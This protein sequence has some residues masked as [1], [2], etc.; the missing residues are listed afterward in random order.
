MIQG[1]STSRQTL[2]S[3]DTFMSQYGS[4]GIANERLWVMPS[5]MKAIL[6][7]EFNTGKTTFLGSN[8]AALIW[9]LDL[10]STPVPSIGA[11]GLAAQM[12]P[13]ISPD[14][15]PIGFDHK[16]FT[17]D[18]DSMV[19]MKDRLLDAAAKNQPRPEMIV[20]D[21][22]TEWLNY[23]RAATLKHFKKDTWDE[24]RGDAMWEWLYQQ[25]NLFLT[26]L[27][28]AGYGVWVSAHISS[29]LVTQGDSTKKVRWS[30]NAPPGFFK[31]FYGTFEMALQMEKSVRPVTEKKTRRATVNGATLEFVEDSTT[32]QTIFT[33]RGEDPERAALL[34]RRV[35]FNP[36]LELPPTEA[37][38]SFES[39][40]L[41]VAK[42]QAT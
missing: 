35:C 13:G 31:R 10:S 41:S 25:I 34:K 15:K 24:G 8:P 4:F 42:P 33:L 32:Y 11:P 39:V 36:I 27:R 21:S 26:E 16:P 28:N 9:N 1:I 22:L 6:I 14:G 5:R 38:K 18:H 29:E 20:I 37:W 40:Y 2:A 17:F 7:G 23:L 12:W 30:L 3:G 19:A